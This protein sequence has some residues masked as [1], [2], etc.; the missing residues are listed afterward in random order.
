MTSPLH[1]ARELLRGRSPW[2]TLAWLLLAAWA[3]AILAAAVQLDGWRQDLSRTLLQLNADARFRARAHTR[4]AVDPEWYRRKALALLTATERL[5]QDAAWTIF[6]PGSWRPFDNLEEQVQARLARE[7]GDIVVETLRRELYARAGQLTGVPLVRGSGDLQMG[8]ECQSPVPQNLERRLTAA[9]EDL[10][11]FVAVA[12]YVANVERLD[13]AVQSFLSLQYAGGQ[14]EQL[15]KLVAYTLGKELPGAL[16]GAVRMFQGSEEV[17]IEP[18]L[19]QS[20]LQWATRCSLSKAMGA[21]HTRLLNTNDLFAL[22]QGYVERSTGLFEPSTRAVAFDRTLERYKAVHALL[23][24]QN[25]LLS[26]GRNDWM[27]QGTLQLGSAYQDVL[28][29][30][31]RTRL[32]GPETLQ[33]LQGQSGAAFIEFRRQFEIAF[34]GH[35]EPGI[36]WLAA[37]NR[38]GLSSERAALRA[39]LSALLKTSFMA[40]TAVPHPAGKD[41]RE[42]GTLPKVLQEA[43]ALASERA[44]A[45]AEVLPLFPPHAQPVVARVVDARVSELIYQRA[46]RIVK[47]AW[48]SDAKG[49]LDTAAFRQQREQVLA[50]Q[51]VLKE[52]GGGGLGDRLVAT[53]DGEL[54]RRLAALQDDWRQQPLQDPRVS[55]FSWWQGDPLPLAQ[56][57]GAADPGSPVPPS[58]S[59]TATRLDLLVQQAKPLLALGS[60]ALAA[61]P[62]AARWLQLQ[63]ELERYAARSSDSSLLRLERYVAAVGPDLRRDNCAER[64]ATAAP[65]LDGDD[66]IARRH[67][68]L[69]QAL[70][71]RCHELRAEAALTGASLTQ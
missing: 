16:E 46:F 6:L 44:R 65:A 47:A 26:K 70:S 51:A 21:L 2:L 71:Q 61:D 41:V 10:P 49:P 23:E 42:A 17:S 66:E 55:D 24:D 25:A 39:G 5:Q 50:L 53:L 63:A 34:G 37:E 56:A 13:G 40:E 67:R 31:E 59:R 22:E 15:R 52:T 11:E 12:D 33:Q 14:P 45:V 48:P 54:V 29:R 58:F 4:E 9:A 68:Q 20:R 32:F 3:L 57:L 38:F 1:R 19:M 30:I 7:F 43:R 62:A 64:L 35:G 28:R 27:R 18:V 36:V 69:H 8:V 60:P